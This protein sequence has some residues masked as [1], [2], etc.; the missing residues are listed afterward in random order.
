MYRSTTNCTIDCNTCVHFVLFRVQISLHVRLAFLPSEKRAASLL[1]KTVCALM[2]INCM[3]KKTFAFSSQASEV[4][5]T[6]L[7]SLI[8]YHVR[9][10]NASEKLF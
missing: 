5:V 6:R 9:N 4:I 1:I 10:L 8:L 7:A 3:K 2:I